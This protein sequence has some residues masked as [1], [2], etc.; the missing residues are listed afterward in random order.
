MTNRIEH[1]LL[2]RL[3]IGFIFMKKTKHTIW[4]TT[5]PATTIAGAAGQ[6]FRNSTGHEDTPRTAVIAAL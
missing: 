6:A 2:F 4:C 5:G 3:N 1:A